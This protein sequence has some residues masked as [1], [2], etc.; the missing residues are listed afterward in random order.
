LVFLIHKEYGR[1]VLRLIEGDF[2]SD[3]YNLMG[4]SHTPTSSFQ[5]NVLSLHVEYF[6]QTWRVFL[7]Y[8]L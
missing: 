3:R 2:V 6:L 1:F 4:V 5:D 7:S 8:I